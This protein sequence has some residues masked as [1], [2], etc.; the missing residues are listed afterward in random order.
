LTSHNAAQATS[1]S[2]SN[3][4]TTGNVVGQWTVADIGVAQPTG[5]NAPEDLYVAVEDTSGNVAVVTSADGTARPG[6]NDWVIP[7]GD[8]S[9]VNL[10]RVAMMYIGVGDR[11][12]PT[13]GGTGLV[14]IDDILV[15]HP[16]AVAEVD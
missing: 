11:D 14:F 12:N 10:S 1:A 6:W 16:A 7:F 3:I 4:S 13:A 15:G 5:G 2:F 8:L 9:G